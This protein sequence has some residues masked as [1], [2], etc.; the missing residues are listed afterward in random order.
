[1]FNI[2]FENKQT[3]QAT[4]L[5]KNNTQ[6]I[7]RA[8]YPVKV[9]SDRRN[10][11]QG[12]VQL[13]AFY[14]D[15]LRFYH[16]FIYT[17]QENITNEDSDAIQAQ[18]SLYMSDDKGQGL[19]KLHP[20]DEYFIQSRWVLDM[21]RYYFTTKKDSNQDGK[22]NLY[23]DSKTY[24]VDFKETTPMVKTYDFMPK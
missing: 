3:G 2:V 16:H 11:T 4:P 7:H 24:Y 21:E 5:F 22:I 10:A 6:M 20:D 13:D 19:K 23:D 1:M 12:E 14:Q 17:V 15:E 18:S 8:D 9:V